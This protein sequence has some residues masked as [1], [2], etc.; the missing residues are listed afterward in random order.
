[1]NRQHIWVKGLD[2]LQELIE[3][4]PKKDKYGLDDLVDI[5]AVLRSENG[6]PWDKVQTHES[7]RKDLLEETYEVLEAIDCGDPAM[8]REE[9]GDV[10]LQVVFHCQIEREKG[11]F[12]LDAVADEVSKKLILR[13][14]HVF[15]EVKADTV[16]KVL[17]NW[18][19]IKKEE[20]GQ[21]TFSDTL[22]SVPK[23]FPSLM[24]AQKL[25]KRAD[26]A[27]CDLSGTGETLALI[28]ERLDA[29]ESQGSASDKDIGSLLM[30]C[31]ELSRQTG[32]D[33]EEA[34]GFECERFTQRFEQLEGSGRPLAEGARALYGEEE[35][36]Q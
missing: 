27:G 10:L 12:D 19:A 28:R 33:A 4:L 2:R 13:H 18:D 31:A 35:N 29:I 32:C 6:C 15:G 8:L 25:T 24:R 21:E 20:K 7:I 26:R 30:L 14:P 22:R 9:L 5:V 16:D 36:K 34:L 23:V 1:M 17:S 3:S 11:I